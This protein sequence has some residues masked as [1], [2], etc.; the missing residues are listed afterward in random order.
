MRTYGL[1][2][3]GRLFEPER[4]PFTLLEP[5][6][7]RWAKDLKRPGPGC[8]SERPFLEMT[9]EE[10]RALR[11]LHSILDGKPLTTEAFLQEPEKRDGVRLPR[12]GLLEYERPLA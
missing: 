2:S 1:I 9:I 3:V 5:T 4:D 6:G 12:V 10:A 7:T 8:W 11:E